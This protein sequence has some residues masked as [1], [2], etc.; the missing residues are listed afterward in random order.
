MTMGRDVCTIGKVPFRAFIPDFREGACHEATGI[1]GRERTPKEQEIL[2]AEPRR[3]TAPAA[4]SP[5]AADRSVLPCWSYSRRTLVSLTLPLPLFAPF[6]AGRHRTPEG[7]RC[8]RSHPEPSTGFT[9]RRPRAFGRPAPLRP[10]FP[11]AR[12]ASSA[13]TPRAGRPDHPP[14]RPAT[15]TQPHGAFLRPHTVP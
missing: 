7:L 9:G 14:A 10:S 6:Q 1:Q 5:A 2:S 8:L 4:A 3:A 13:R 11:E 15:A 12:R